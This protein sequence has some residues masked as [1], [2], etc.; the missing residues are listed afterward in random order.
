MYLKYNLNVQHWNILPKLSLVFVS[1]LLDITFFFVFLS[2]S[3]HHKRLS[4]LPNAFNWC[5]RLILTN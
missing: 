3:A 1:C 4:G 5:F 2:L